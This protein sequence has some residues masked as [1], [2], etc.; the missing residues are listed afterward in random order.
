MIKPKPGQQPRSQFDEWQKLLDMQERFCNKLHLA[1]QAFFETE[2]CVQ[3]SDDSGVRDVGICSNA[4]QPGD[5]I[6]LINGVK[7][8]LIVRREGQGG[9]RHRADAGAAPR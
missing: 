8:P 5:K 6:V 9:K 3:E 1:H 4:V 2:G 7:I